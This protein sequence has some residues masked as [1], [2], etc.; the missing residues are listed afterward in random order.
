L[1]SWF[2]SEH[3][4]G[5]WFWIVSQGQFFHIDLIY[6]NL[7]NYLLFEFSES[8]LLFLSS[9]STYDLWNSDTCRSLWHI[10][11]HWIMSIS[12]ITISIDVLV[13]LYVFVSVLHSFIAYSLNTYHKS[14]Y[15]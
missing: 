1:C 4:W 12:Q 8:F 15:V 10:W 7:F 14:A 5:G 13:S 3:W 6:Y 11:L 2:V 9:K